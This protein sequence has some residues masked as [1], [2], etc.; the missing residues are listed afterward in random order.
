MPLHAQKLVRAHGDRIEF[1]AR[2]RAD[3]KASAGDGIQIN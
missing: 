1:A 3:G 2:V